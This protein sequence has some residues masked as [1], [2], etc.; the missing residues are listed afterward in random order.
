[1]LTYRED[2]WDDA[3][4][5]AEFNRLLKDIFNLDLTLWNKKGFW[6]RRFRPFSYFDRD[7]LIS[8]VCLY[9]LDMMVAGKPCQ[10]AQISSVA[11][12]PEYRRRGLN[13]ELTEKA[14]AWAR[15]THE[16]FFLFADEEAVPYYRKCGFRA[17][18]EHKARIKV[19]GQSSSPGA[20]KL[21]IED[22]DHWKQIGDLAAKRVP[23]SETLGVT[24]QRLF[25]FWCLY[26]MK[27]CI[28]YVAELDLLI[29]YERKGETVIVS[30][31]VGEQIPPFSE[32]YPYICAATD[33]A[34]EFLFMPDRLG[35]GQLDWVKVT[36]N[37][38]HLLGAFPLESTE[39]I[40]PLT[41]HA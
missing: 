5:K 22:P 15:D 1:M 30:D 36:E 20:T 10:V 24:N 35:L 11:T 16:F 17:V 27:D 6:D 28:H 32:I 12:L 3:D 33:R 26:W 41:A 29:L 34:V 31:I 14:L 7:K 21:D 13:R 40:F 18:D 9:S 39:F 37:G 8:S 25:M 23:V 19:S 2:Y 38:T 4:S